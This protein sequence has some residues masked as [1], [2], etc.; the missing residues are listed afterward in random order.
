MPLMHTRETVE[1]IIE[2]EHAILA[3]KPE[4]EIEPL[5]AK[6][7]ELGGE[8]AVD[9]ANGCREQLEMEDAL[10]GPGE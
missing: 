1:A 8:R 5:L 2:A 3:R 6:V 9:D 10:A 7:R 4:A